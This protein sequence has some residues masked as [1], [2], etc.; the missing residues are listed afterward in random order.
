[1]A[2]KKAQLDIGVDSSKSESGFEKI[3]R[4]AAKMSQAVQKSGEAASKGVDGIGNGADASAKKVDKATQSLAASIQR[5]TAAM[6]AGEKGTSKYYEALASQRGANAEVLTPYLKK[7]KEVEAMHGRAGIS[8]GQLT[9]AMRNV[10]AQFTDI[11]T[12]LQGG[13]PPLTVMLQQGG[14]LKDMF[15]GIGNAA[16]ALG[17]YVAGLVTPFTILAAA[18][19]AAGLAWYQGGRESEAFGKAL[20]L[21]GNAAGT[22]AGQMKLMAGGISAISGTQGAAAEALAIFAQSAKVGGVNLEE[23]TGAA[24]RFSKVSGQSVEEVAKQFSELAKDPLAATLKLNDGMNYLTV[25]TYSQIKALTDQGK[26]TEAANIAQK[27]FADTLNDRQ[28]EMKRNLGTIER[29]WEAIAG[30]VGKAW[31]NAKNFGRDSKEKEIDAI[32][33]EIKRREAGAS[34]MYS[35]SMLGKQNAEELQALRERE[36]L[37]EMQIS[38]E[39]GI[40]AEKA[41]QAELVRARSDADKDGLKYLTERQRMERDIAQ[42]TETLVRAGASREEIEKRIA[43]IKSSYAQK[44]LGSENELSDIKAKIDA[45]K[46]Y[47]GR[48]SD[49]S[50]LTPKLTEA[51]KQALK[52]QRELEGAITGTARA[53]KEKA[54]ASAQELVGLEKAQG[55]LEETKTIYQK[56]VAQEAANAVMGKGTTAIE[57]YTL[58]EL[59]RQK[60]ELEAAGKGTPEYIAA[61]EQKIK[62]QERFVASLNAADY[63]TLNAGIDEWMRSSVEAGKI[64]ADE[65][66]LAGLT[67]LERAKVVAQRQVELQLAKEI[68]KIDQSTLDDTDKEALRQ[69]ARSTA[70]IASAT[71]TA[72]AVQDE[73]TKVTDQINQ[74]LTDSLMRGFEA[75]KSFAQSLKDSIVNS[76]K[77]MVLRPIIQFVMAPVSGMLASMFGY[78]GMANATGSSGAVGQGVQMMNVGSTVSSVYSAVTTSFAALGDKV[79]FAAQDIGAWLQMNTTGVLNSAGSSI[80][81]ASNSLGT[82]S[83][84]AGGALAGY[85]IGKAISGQYSTGLGKNTLEVGGT[86]IGA[87]LGGPIGAA[88]GGAIG[89]V[90]NRAFGMGSVDA[91]GGGVRGTFN[92]KNGADIQAYSS[93]HQDGGWFRSDRSGTN[94]S[95]VSS[96]LDQFLDASLKMTAEA[97]K[98]YA[99]LVGLNADAISG[100]SKSIDISLMGLD[101]AGQEKAIADAISGFGEDMAKQLL[102]TFKTVTKSMKFLGM[103]LAV[104]TTVEWIAGPYVRAGETA[105]A[106]LSRLATSL[107]GVNDIL[108]TLGQTAMTA[109]LPMADAASKLLDMFGGLDKYAGLASQYLQDYYTEQERVTLA[110]RNVSEALSKLGVAMPSTAGA[111][112]KLIESQDLTTEAGRKM[113]V[114]LMQLAPAFADVVKAQDQAAAAISQEKT[115]LQSQLDQLLGNTT[116]LRERERAAL[117]ASNRALYDQI[118]A[119][120]D[121]KAAAEAIKDAMRSVGDEVDRLRGI[122]SNS[123]AASLQSQFATLTAQARAG[124]KTAL[125]KLPEISK[126]LEE[127]RKQQ[128]T[129]LLEETRLRAWLADSLAETLRIVGVKVPKFAEGGMHEGGMRLVG[130]KGPELE[131]TGPARYYNADQTKGL[132]GGNS[133]LIDEIKALRQENRAQA[134]SISGL[135][136]RVAKLLERWDGSGMPETREV[137]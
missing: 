89:G 73:W 100:Y 124:D 24:L 130:E 69:K 128:A 31:D 137:A 67:S 33:D 87:I 29:S 92:A 80:M 127:A 41:R 25:S 48:M 77:T 11:V 51:E 75:G 120:E 96:E 50:A 6:E 47:I 118:K 95:A 98:E 82:F 79:A 93:W 131:I 57:A 68:S 111:Y 5:T 107:G 126:A 38:A 44:N 70:A 74:S 53:M 1:M 32:R 134:S 83:S 7:L 108:K 94:Y 112:R 91:T 99:K 3:E 66:R 97:T 101:K 16:K 37:L 19:S 102:G 78:S 61:L 104:G 45:A 64:Y 10:P 90:I 49:M 59:E 85:G 4:S 22:T 54:L 88:I 117:D 23:F 106:A 129:S 15:G 115:G 84:Y 63:K 133:E 46:E 12:S 28:E 60:A 9:A 110:T 13:Q 20:I 86:A 27:A 116:A 17:G 39:R 34:S 136:L 40:G 35:G 26:V 14:Q 65:A 2:G 36:S 123:D 125:D 43:L 52:I 42:Q 119:I 18:A 62:A 121:Q 105:S 30:F 21:S 113:Y 71:A 76:F 58:A 72:K 122:S 132:L 55:T 81:Q 56:A 8:A 103:E 114:S 109:S 135:Q